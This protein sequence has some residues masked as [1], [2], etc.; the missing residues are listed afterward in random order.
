MPDESPMPLDAGADAG[1]AAGGARRWLPGLFV[2]A[3]FALSAAVWRRL[4]DEMPI[5]WDLAGRPNG[6]GGR[7]AGALLLPMIALALWAILTVLPRLDPRRANYAKFQSSYDLVVAATVATL[8]LLHVAIVGNAL[9]WPIPIL[10]VVPLAMG[11]LFVVLGNVL[12]RARPNWWFGIRT[13]WTL[14]NARVWARTQR[15][16]GFALVASGVVA[17]ASALLPSRF[18][19]PVLV[20]AVVAAAIFS[21]GYSYFAWR[22]ESTR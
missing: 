12:P 7:A 21:V 17:I 13:P 2:A 15:V 1:P 22:Q 11:I 19:L 14:S 6:W 9:G 10:R 5:H 16:G 18:A 4:P 20:A 8:V 3:A